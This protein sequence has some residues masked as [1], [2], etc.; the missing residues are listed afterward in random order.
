MPKFKKNTSS[1]MMKKSPYK[2]DP[3]H[4]GTKKKT[5]LGGLLGGLS[6]IGKDIQKGFEVAKEKRKSIPSSFSIPKKPYQYTGLSA[7]EKIALRKQ[8]KGY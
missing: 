2:M 7:K 4:K 8:T 5:F 1:F 3:K 6:K